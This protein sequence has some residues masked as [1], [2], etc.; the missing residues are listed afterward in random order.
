MAMR[1]FLAIFLAGIS[2]RLAAEP[3]TDR[4]LATFSA[5][6]TVPPGHGMMGGKWLSKSVADPLFAKGFMLAGAQLEPVVFV[7]VDWCEIRNDALTRGQTVLAEAAG[8][9]PERV[10]VCAVHQ[11]EAPVADLE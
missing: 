2:L 9:R 8:T 6:V 7:S 3:G 10:M 11:H 5:D 4:R 1:L